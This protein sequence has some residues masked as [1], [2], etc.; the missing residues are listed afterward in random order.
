ML[1]GDNSILNKAGQ[2]RD[3]TGQR[4]IEERIQIAYLGVMANEEGSFSRNKFVEELDKTFGEGKYTLST[5]GSTLTIDGKDYE[6]G[7]PGKW[8][9][10]EKEALQTN[11]IKIPENR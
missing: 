8:S 2:A 10:A 4:D 3:I 9:K 5:D 11:G 7:L 6:T 1:S